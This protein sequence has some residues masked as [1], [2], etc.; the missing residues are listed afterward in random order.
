MHGLP[1]VHL[2]RAP[3]KAGGGA[4]R[5]ACP[6]CGRPL[7]RKEGR[8][9]TFIACSGYPECDYTRDDGTPTGHTCPKCGGRVLEKRSRK[10]RPYYKCENNACDFLSFYPLL[11]EACPACGWPLVKKGEKALCLNP[12]CPEHEPSLL[13]APKEAKKGRS[14]GKGKPPSPP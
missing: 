13:P 14:R 11:E 8:Y 10:G 3:G 1:G 4:H 6:K 9:G 7:L 12:A 2:H 5:E